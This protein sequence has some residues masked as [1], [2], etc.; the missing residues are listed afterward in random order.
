MHGALPL[1]HR[2]DAGGQLRES[3]VELE[4][5]FPIEDRAVLV[6]VQ[7]LFSEDGLLVPHGAR[8]PG[9]PPP[10][11]GRQKRVYFY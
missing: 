7:L 11:R 8:S 6:V 10:T 4:D 1:V 9:D 5:V 3:R 2:A